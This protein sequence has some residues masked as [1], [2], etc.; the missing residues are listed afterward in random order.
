[1]SAAAAHAEQAPALRAPGIPIP[2]LVRVELRK[3]VDTRAG[4]WLFI[5]MQGLIMACFGLAS[6]N[7]GSL[8]MLPLG[9]VAGTA[10]SVQGVVGTIGGALLGLFIGQAFDG[11]ARPFLISLAVC[12]TAALLILFWTERGRLFG[13]IERNEAVPAADSSPPLT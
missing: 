4:L 10:S 9:H 13:A 12:A 5:A 3:T 1:M 7:C 2:R 6:S 8:A 11:T